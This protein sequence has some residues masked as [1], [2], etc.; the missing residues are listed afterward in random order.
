M[1]GGL[2]TGAGGAALGRH[3]ADAKGRNELTLPGSS[4]GLY[5]EGIREQ[6]AELTR[7]AGLARSRKP[8]AHFHADPPADAG[9]TDAEFDAH[10]ARLEA[11]FGLGAQPY[12]EAIHV[13]EGREHRHRVYSLL[14]PDGITV[15]LS[16]SYQRQEKLSRIAEFLAG[17]EMTSGAHNRA[18]I[19][20]LE[21]DGPEATA[22]LR[23]EVAAAMRA[24]GLHEGP[25]PRAPTTPPERAQGNAPEP[26]RRTWRCR[27][28]R[29]GS[30]QTAARRSWKRSGS[31]G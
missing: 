22:A 31:V 27:P 5:S 26:G 7:L 24:T 11:E 23:A 12:A 14:R 9:W 29:L 2:T 20:A 18:V 6:V 3:L 15:R 1:I 10:W 30:H 28:S 17:G 13:K 16:H 4:R 21:K 25:R 8:V 19:R